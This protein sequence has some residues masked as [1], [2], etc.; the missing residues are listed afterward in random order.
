MPKQQFY[1]GVQYVNA[2]QFQNFLILTV[3]KIN[4]LFK[5]N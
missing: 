3:G 5:I 2:E 4:M 1:F